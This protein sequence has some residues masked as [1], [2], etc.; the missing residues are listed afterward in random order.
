MDGKL[1]K[2]NAHVVKKLPDGK[3]YRLI[4]HSHHKSTKAH[5]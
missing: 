3:S 5:I 2:E 1:S 4:A